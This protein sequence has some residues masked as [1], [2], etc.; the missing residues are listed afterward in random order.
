MAGRLDRPLFELLTQTWYNVSWSIIR[1]LDL[2]EL[3]RCIS[4]I[5]VSNL[6]NFLGLNFGG[7]I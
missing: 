7:S 4:P 3:E 5:L 2:D 1:R 6:Q